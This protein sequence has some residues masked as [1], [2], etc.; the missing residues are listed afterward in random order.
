MGF[1]LDMTGW[2]T[3]DLI[4]RPKGDSIVRS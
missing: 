3:G 4:L 1:F 2:R